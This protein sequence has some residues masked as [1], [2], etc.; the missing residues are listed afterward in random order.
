MLTHYKAKAVSY[1]RKVPH[2]LSNPNLESINAEKD[3]DKPTKG[4]RT[5]MAAVAKSRGSN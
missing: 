4:F 1:W 3:Q 2:L 5:E